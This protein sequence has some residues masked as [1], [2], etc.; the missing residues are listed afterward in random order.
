VEAARRYI[1]LYEG[2]TGR[3]FEPGTV[4]AGPRIARVLESFLDR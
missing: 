1:G 2:L 4:P 3:S